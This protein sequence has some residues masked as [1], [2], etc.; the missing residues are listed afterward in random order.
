[1]RIPA[2]LFAAWLLL[3][4][5]GGW[6]AAQTQ[7]SQPVVSHPVASA[8]SPRLSDMQLSPI[9]EN[10]LEQRE[11]PTPHPLPPRRGEP[12]ASNTNAPLQT[13]TSPRGGIAPKSSFPGLGANGY[14][15]PDPNIAVGA[16]TGCGG[17]GCIVQVVNSEM[18]VFSKAGGPAIYGPVTLS[19]LWKNLGGPCATNNAGDPVVQY[20]AAA[21]RW[22]IS[23]LGS[24]SGS[25]YSECIAVSQSNDPGGAYNLHQF[26]IQNYSGDLNDYPK[27]SVWPT[28]INGSPTNSAYLA[29]YNLFSGSSFV[30]GALCAYD[31]QAMLSGAAS[32]AQICFIVPND[33]GYLPA[34][35]DAKASDFSSTTGAL[36]T[37]SA[38]AYFLN[39]DALNSLRLYELDNLTFANGTASATLSSPTDIAVASFSEAC[40]GGTCIPQ[41]NKQK[42]DSLGDRLMYRL[43]YRV[44]S[45]HDAMIVNHSVTV[46]SRVGVRWYELRQSSAASTQC[47]SF[48]SNAF[49]VCQQGT[50]SPDAAFRWMGSAAMD[51]LG[52]MAIGYSKSSSTVY[53]SVAY[54]SRSPGGLMGTETVMQAGIGAQTNYSRWGDYTSLRI[55]PADDATFWYTN[56]YYTHNT[57]VFN[58]MWSTVVGSFKLQ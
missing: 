19:S 53:P 14:L 24:T 56:E 50:Y 13:E 51:S 35:L 21:D 42:L 32:P 17:A 22:L 57:K 6:A 5:S 39:F 46:G 38:P 49:Y 48:T 29:T 2:S 27:F 54:T 30:G 45:D 1:M 58:F 52:N 15:P 20:D 33:G 9:V 37:F 4:T 25:S 47:A 10:P 12:G 8:V 3:A 28:Q 41:P 44:F 31:R 11:A 7:G 16:N 55:D 40:N 26:Q 36:W 23:Q 18:A 34:D 43:A